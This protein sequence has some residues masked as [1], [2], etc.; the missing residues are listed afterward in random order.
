MTGLGAA[1]SGR[2]VVLEAAEVA[3]GICRSHPVTGRWGEW[4]FDY[5]GGHWVFGGD[6]ML[7]AF[8]SQFAEWRR[9][10]R[11]SSVWLGELERMIPF[12]LQ[13]HLSHLPAAL[14]SDAWRE[15]CRP[16]AAPPAVL[17]DWL[18]AHFGPSLY[19]LFF[20]PFHDLYTA[21]LTDRI[22]A[23]DFF[24]TPVDLRAVERGLRGESSEAGYNASFLYPVGGLSAF[25]RR[26]SEG[27]DVRLGTCV[28]GI[29]LAGHAVQL[30]DGR[31]LGYRRMICTLPL[32]ETVRMA[33]LPLAA[34]PHTS[35]LVLNIGARRGAGCPPDHWV[36]FPGSA[37]GFHRV[38]FYSNVDRAF[39]PAASPTLVSLY[40]ERALP[41]GAK[42][43]PEE[44]AAYQR[45]VVEELQRLGY[46]EDVD[47]LS[48]HWL[49]VA[50]T[51]R[52]VGSAWR[53]EAAEALA[54]QE[55]HVAGRYGRWRFQG[56]AE[57][58][59]E[60]LLAGSLLGASR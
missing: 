15:M 45:V 48:A 3:G 4:H 42:P 55:V 43:S 31:T 24:K 47:V 56:I 36:Y 38:G 50:Y 20:G 7:S 29:D 10:Q 25:V 2:G 18:R 59:R 26:L 52:W 21:G 5:G 32:H 40:V 33:G 49:E 22:A 44:L 46:I 54:R 8:L 12:P 16:P 53:E 13:N 1:R 19:R 57:S 9:Y 41:A 28:A 37:A 14:A 17:G 6:A 60:G 11:R 23:D 51:W 35:V 27:C 30:R 34:D 58:L 39:L